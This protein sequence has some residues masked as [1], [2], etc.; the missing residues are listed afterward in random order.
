MKSRGIVIALAALK[1]GTGCDDG[2]SSGVGPTLDCY[3]LTD[4]GICNLA[5]TNLPDASCPSALKSGSCPSSD[6]GSDLVG[7]CLQV[8][9]SGSYGEPTLTATN[10][11]CY[12]LAD[13]AQVAM[14]E[15]TAGLV[16]GAEQIWSKTP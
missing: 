10:G 3:E 5:S 16:N 8:L 2:G 13:A 15:C 4:A 14:S 1:M 12:Y 11:E 9:S 6:L 7:C